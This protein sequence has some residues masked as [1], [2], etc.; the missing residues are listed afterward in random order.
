MCLLIS[1]HLHLPK[2][3]GKVRNAQAVS[4]LEPNCSG[5]RTVDEVIGNLRCF[6]QLWG[7]AVKG[8]IRS[9]FRGCVM[10]EVAHA[11]LTEL[12]SPASFLIWHFFQFLINVLFH[13]ISACVQGCHWDNCYPMILASAPVACSRLPDGCHPLLVAHHEW[14]GAFCRSVLQKLGKRQEP[15]RNLTEKRRMKMKS[16][17]PSATFIY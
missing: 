15:P 3:A 17:T 8:Q 16:K 2:V 9:D 1:S 5:Y 12:E 7:A 13:C 4:Y 11:C 14:R 6:S 10:H